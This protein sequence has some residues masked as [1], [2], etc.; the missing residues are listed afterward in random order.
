MEV[1][2]SEISRT[3]YNYLFSICVS[4][5]KVQDRNLSICKLN[6]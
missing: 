1:G 4:T 2:L 3:A 6:K 5:P